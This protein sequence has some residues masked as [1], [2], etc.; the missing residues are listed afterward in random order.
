ME[1]SRKS[2]S[3]HWWKFFLFALALAALKLAGLFVFIVGFFVALPIA[4]AALMFTYEEMFAAEPMPASAPPI[5]LSDTVRRWGWPIGAA[6]AFLLLLSM[7]LAWT[8]ERSRH[9][10]RRARAVP[11]RAAPPAQPAAKAAAVNWLQGEWVFDAEHFKE[12][13]RVAAAAA[14]DDRQKAI[15]QA[16]TTA[17]FEGSEGMTWTITPT[18][19]QS[20]HPGSGTRKG[21]YRIV[22]KRDADTVEAEVMDEG[23]PKR[24]IFHREG[25]R[26][27]L[28][29]A[30][31][32]PKNP[33][34]LPAYYKKVTP[35]LLER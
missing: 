34:D 14:T 20:H 11:G 24:M 25:E 18:E 33:L 16:L 17:T 7:V 32:D 35:T 6:V 22:R 4:I 19:M 28:S 12:Q 13:A 26:L 27:C 30:N 15:L 1:L 21:P 5:V 9:Q 2:I 29:M 8:G 10:V 23:K 3:K 31:R